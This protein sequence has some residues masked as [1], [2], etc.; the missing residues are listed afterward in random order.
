M[1]RRPLKHLAISLV[2]VTIASLVAGAPRTGYAA[3]I[4]RPTVDKLLATFDDVVFG[5]EIEASARAKVVAKWQEPLRITV[6]GH[7]KELHINYLREHLK[8]VRELTGLSLAAVEPGSN[9]EN[10]TLI[11]VPR[12]QMSKISVN[13]VDPKT[14]QTLSG[15]GSCYFLSFRDPPDTILRSVIVINNERTSRAINHCL[16]EET[17][18]SLGLPNDSNLIR[19][20]VFSDLDSETELTRSDRILVQTLYDPRLLPGTPREQALVVARTII[21]ELDSRLPYP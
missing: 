9:P 10:V 16:L 15:P 12:I 13:T 6:K 7:H 5:A 20:S 21:E 14:I 4:G 8:T 11:F 17:V 18:Q 3:D 19:P 1:V 2:V